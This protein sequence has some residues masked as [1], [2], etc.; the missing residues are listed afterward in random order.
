[1]ALGLLMLP[2]NNDPFTI[3]LNACDNNI[4]STGTVC[5][6]GDDIPL[7]CYCSTDAGFGSFT[8]CLVKGYHNNT[9]LIHSF[10]NKCNHVTSTSMDWQQFW[11]NYTRTQSLIK[12]P[13][14][15]TTFNAT[16]L[17]SYPIS[18][19]M[20][21]FLIDKD[22]MYVKLMNVNYGQWFGYGLLGYWCGVVLVAT[23][24]NWTIY[25]FPNIVGKFTGPISNFWRKNITL[26]ALYGKRKAHSYRRRFL[27]PSRMQVIIMFVFLILV[28][29]FSGIGIRWV[30]GNSVYPHKTGN[31]AQLIAIRIGTLIGS[32]CPLLILF[33]ARNNVLQW[34]TRWN[35][36]TFVTFHKGISR[37]VVILM[38]IHAITFTTLDKIKGVYLKH[39]M[40]KHVRWGVVAGISVAILFVQSLLYLR[41]KAYETFLLIHIVMSIIFITAAYKHTVSFGYG[42]YYYA[43]IGVW[44]FDR[45]IR[46]ARLAAFGSP[47]ATVTLLAEETLRV[48]IPKPKYWHTVPGGHAF[49]H[50][51][52][53]SCFWQSHPFTFTD[54]SEE[55]NNITM[56]I[57]LK[58]GI[59]HGLYQ[60]LAQFPGA[61]TKV[62]VLVEGPY[63][64]P[65]GARRYKNSLFI[66]GGNGIPGIY[67]EVLDLG[68]RNSNSQLKLMWIIREWKSLAW[69]YQELKTLNAT[70]IATTVYVS[71]PHNS[72]GLHHLRGALSESDSE[73]SLN[74]ETTRIDDSE[75]E[76]KSDIKD[77]SPVDLIKSELNHITFIEGRPDIEE[78]VQNEIQQADGS[79]AFV[80]CGHPAMVDD[81]RY[82]VANNLPLSNHRME[83]FEQLQ[84]W[85]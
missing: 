76:Q 31:I 27:I 58:G 38:V 9:K 6:V 73:S 14:T 21:Q 64:A 74:M 81:V 80:T 52:R 43:A 15:N 69:F 20:N 23:I 50:F 61:T 17:I 66:A 41:R 62:R 77:Y 65:S 11:A 29:A 18:I 7:P 49:I 35:F 37:V 45:V 40:T 22:F 32:L 16:E 2:D 51:L 57:K 19:D 48:V 10:I 54:C 3:A 46:F 53:P 39:L 13:S 82:A 78:I 59:T 67:S 26:S 63:G 8:N 71:Q 36:A 84:V 12:D 24:V 56:Y 75:K 47:Q 5:E 72:N 85:T 83:F 25:L 42:A 44:A 33:S 55:N 68:K 79:T 60:H 4:E 1:M 70:N 28:S 34:I 30:G